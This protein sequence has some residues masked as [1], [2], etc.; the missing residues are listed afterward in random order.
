MS[1]KIRSAKVHPSIGISRVGNSPNE[2]FIGPEIPGVPPLPA[3][4]FKD[5][6]G[7]IKR[8][9][10]LFRVYGYDADGSPL[11]ELTCDNAE[12]EWAVHL[13][14]KKASWKQF[15]SR[16]VKEE[17]PLR[18]RGVTNR[19]LLEIDPGP[20]TI[21]GRCSKN[22]NGSNRYSFDSGTFFNK[23]VYLGELQTDE[24]GR[25]LVLGGRGVSEPTSSDFNFI[26]HYANNDNWHDDVS[27]GP[28]MANVKVDGVSID[29]IP[30]WVIVAPPDFS[31][32]TF[33]LVTAYDVMA[34]VANDKGWLKNA[35]GVSFTRDIFPI[36]WRCNGYTWVSENSLHGHG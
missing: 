25:L 32:H 17:A 24:A 12:I 3:G 11:G 28:V 8:Q 18:N 20:R 9:T 34:Q 31:P 35:E 30:A 33:N 10:P 5:R 6:S 36:F 22:R 27:D 1:L 16:F 29:V 4:G 15:Q 13:A 23:P 26:R 2:F 7:R 14:N 21:S 19:M